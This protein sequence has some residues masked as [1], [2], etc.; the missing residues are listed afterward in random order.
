MPSTII[1]LPARGNIDRIYRFTSTRDGS[2]Q[3]R[4]Y[5]DDDTN[6]HEPPS[7]TEILEVA[8]LTLTV[9]DGTVEMEAV[10]DLNDGREQS[11]RITAA[12]RVVDAINAWR[13]GK[14]LADIRTETAATLPLTERL[15]AETEPNRDGLVE[16]DTR[17]VTE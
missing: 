11:V 4:V 7:I 8:G 14:S 13:A 12:Q 1:T 15:R 17:R 6:R 9:A 5:S 10:T 16:V 3:I 2:D